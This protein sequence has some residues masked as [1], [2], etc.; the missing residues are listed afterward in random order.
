[1]AL[2]FNVL[3]THAI[4]GYGGAAGSAFAAQ[5]NSL[6][7]RGL[8]FLKLDRLDEALSDYNAALKLTESLY[9]RS[10]VKLKKNDKRGSEQDRKAAL[11]LRLGIVSDFNEMGF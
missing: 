6:D 11:R 2:I 1:M 10:I 4:R 8:V 3:T 5:W 7:T 9:G